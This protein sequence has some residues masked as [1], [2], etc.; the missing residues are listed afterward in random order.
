MV[1]RST[2]D[3]ILALYEAFFVEVYTYC[4]HR[5]F[6]RDLAEDAAAAV[7]LRL[8]EKHGELKERTKASI[9]NWLYGTASNVVALHV[10]DSKRRLAIT[11]ELSRERSSPGSDGSA[12]SEK[13][14][15]PALYEAISRLPQADQDVITM[16]YFGGLDSIAIAEAMGITRIAARVRLTRAIKRLRRELG[17]TPWLT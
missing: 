8:V 10:R 17:T 3:E 11:T 12:A 2:Q 15:W 16:R 14:D 1:E 6:S 9:R 5:L 4:A 13:L 7:F